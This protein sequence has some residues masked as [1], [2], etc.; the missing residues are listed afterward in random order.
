MF[1][2]FL[3][4]AKD[5]AMLAMEAQTVIGIR[6]WQF[7]LGGPAVGVEAQRMVNEKVSALA[8]AAMVLATGGSAHEIVEGYREHVQT[9][10]QRLTR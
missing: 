4:L 1:V 3:S 5:T 8:E 10:V 9:N 2:P 7:S 6:L